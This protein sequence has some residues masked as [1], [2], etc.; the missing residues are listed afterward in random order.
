MGLPT[1]ET[2]TQIIALLDPVYP[3]NN[4]YVDRQLSKILISL[5][6]PNAVS[7]TIALMDV[8]K[9]DTLDQKP[10]TESS[11]LI[12][13]NLQYGMDIA[14]HVVESSPAQQTYYAIMPLSAAKEG[15]TPELQDKY[16]KWFANAF[17]NY[18]GGQSFVGFINRGQN[19]RVSE[20]A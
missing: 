13:R 15:W 17:V 16:F 10:F 11:D 20:C 8:A 18:K 14:K 6:A 12:F 5:Q 7:K 1:G 3:A 4:Y 19:A 9:D 2:R